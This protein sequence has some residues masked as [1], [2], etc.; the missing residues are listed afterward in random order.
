MYCNA[1]PDLL[2]EDSSD[3]S[4]K[5]DSDQMDTAQSM[6]FEGIGLGYEK[7]K[8]VI[9]RLPR[10]EKREMQDLP[11]FPIFD[12]FSKTEEEVPPA[13]IQGVGVREEM[14]P[15]TNE[16]PDSSDEGEYAKPVKEV[17]PQ[18]QYEYDNK[19]RPTK[20]YHVADRNEEDEKPSD[21]QENDLTKD[22]IRILSDIQ[23]AQENAIL[24]PEENDNSD[25]RMRLLKESEEKK[26]NSFLISPLIH[27]NIKNVNSYIINAPRQADINKILEFKLQNKQRGSNQDI[28][29][30][31]SL[32]NLPHQDVW[33]F[34]EGRKPKYANAFGEFNYYPLREDEQVNDAYFGKEVPKRKW[35]NRD[36]PKH[37]SY[38]DRN[39][40]TLEY[41]R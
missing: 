11:Q 1:N 15:Y 21:N 29:D 40:S 9:I 28:F 16:S 41:Y 13:F 19:D 27:D 5:S 10:P 8:L 7:G 25:P 31:G 14:N 4:K 39:P 6:P 37:E 33:D 17:T 24:Q 38:R 32:T 2:I 3:S 35:Y 18:Q 23:K 22:L 20:P 34:K 30:S 26:L 36:Q 12:Y